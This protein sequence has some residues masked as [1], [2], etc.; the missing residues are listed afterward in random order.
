MVRGRAAGLV[1]HASVVAVRMAGRASILSQ[2]ACPG[3]PRGID[4]GAMGSGQ[5]QIRA[6]FALATLWNRAPP[7]IADV[8]ARS[9]LPAWLVGVGRGGPR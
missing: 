9:G 5:E 6:L 2:T 7:R 4:R 1:W 3:R 8:R